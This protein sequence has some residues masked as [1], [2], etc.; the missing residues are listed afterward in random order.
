MTGAVRLSLF[1]PF[2]AI[3]CRAIVRKERRWAD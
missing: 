1:C 3:S 2:G